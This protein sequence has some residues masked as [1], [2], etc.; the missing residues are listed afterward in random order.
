MYNIQNLNHSKP[1]VKK[2]GTECSL[3]YDVQMQIRT[4][5]PLLS[6]PKSNYLQFVCG[7]YSFF[8]FSTRISAQRQVVAIAT[9]GSRSKQHT[10]SV[11][12]WWWLSMSSSKR[13]AGWS[14]SIKTTIRFEDTQ[15]AGIITLNQMIV[16]ILYDV[17]N[18]IKV[19]TGF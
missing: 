3:K 2:E 12:L 18:V 1:E 9:S 8:P 5:C 19:F 16:V 10:C 7:I 17:R 6:N 4:F 14:R 13:H 11:F 15:E